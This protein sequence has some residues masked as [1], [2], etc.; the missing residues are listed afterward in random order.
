MHDTAFRGRP[1]HNCPRSHSC[2][3]P[4]HAAELPVQ[5][6]H[7][8]T[9]QDATN[10]VRILIVLPQRCVC[11]SYRVVDEQYVIEFDDVVE[12]RKDVR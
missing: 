12:A 8:A 11:C 10:S 9:L 1:E 5:L 4:L 2:V 3:T 7:H 6:R